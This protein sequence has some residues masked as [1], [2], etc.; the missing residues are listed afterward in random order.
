[1]A[2]TAEPY[3][4]QKTLDIVFAASCA[5]MML[6]TIWMF[7]ADYRRD[8]KNTQRTFRDVEATLAEREMLDKLPDPALVADLR[9][10]VKAAKK[11][12]AKAKESV[13]DTERKLTAKRESADEHYRGIKADLDAESSYYNIAADE[14][15]SFPRESARHKSLLDE[16]K[17]IREKKVLPL[18]KQLAAA[19]TTLNEIDAEIKE[20]VRSVTDEPEKE[21]AAAEDELKKQTSVFDR[22]AKLASQK[23]WGSGDT[24]R[25]LP[26][27][28]GFESSTKIR[29]MWL[30]DLTIDMGGF[31]DAAR[32]DRCTTCHLGIDRATFEPERLASIGDDD[33]NRRL[34]GKLVDAQKML[35]D[36]KNAGE[37]LGFDPADLPGE[38]NGSV[39]WLALIMFGCVLVGA[40]SL[41]ALTQSPRV[42]VLLLAGG[43]L[44][45]VVTS[46]LFAYFA[47]RKPA[48]KTI[49]L[50]KSQVMEYASHPRLDL[51]VGGNSPHNAEKFGC[52]IC[53]AGQG[54]ATEFNLATHTPDDSVQTHAWQK[55]YHYH[56]SHDWDFPMLPKR[57]IESSCLKCHHQVTDLIRNGAKEEAPKLLRGF[58]LVKD[59]GCFGCHE[60][61][62]NK[63]GR[64]IGPDLRLESSP[65]LDL[66]TA[67][68]QER[69]KASQPGTLRK[70]GPS[71]R[72]LAEKTGPEWTTNW[73]NAPRD[74]RPDTKMP[75]F[76]HLVTNSKGD[77]PG[78]LPKD[79]ENFPAAEVHAISHYLLAESKAT[80]N[81]SDFYREALLKGKQNLNALQATLIK[82][83]LSDR[84]MK[85]LLDMSRRFVD[86]AI[87]SV[88]LH[89]QTINAHATRQRLLQDRIAELQRVVARGG[90][91]PEV[92]TEIDAAGK[93]LLAATDSLVK[94]GT[95]VSLADGLIDGLGEKVALPAADGNA[96]S[97]QRLFAEK[98][99]LACHGHEGTAKAGT[100]PDGKP[101]PAVR[102]AANFGPELSRIADK[103]AP[104][105]DKVTARMW[106]V[107]WLLNPNVH[108]PRTKMPITHL[109]VA[110]ANDVATWL[111]SQKTGWKGAPTDPVA[112]SVKDYKDL[113]RVYLAKS[114]GM[115]RTDLDIFFP[116]DGD[117]LAGISPERLDAMPRDADERVLVQG[118][119]TVE[120]LK[121]YIGKKAIGRQ[122]CYGCHD[123]PGFETAKPIGTDLNDW[124][125]KD[126]ARLAFEDGA[127]FVK[128]YYNVVPT[129]RTR[130]EVTARI[131][132]LTKKGDAR[133][134]PEKKE[135]KKLEDQADNQ[136]K[137]IALE[138]KAAG[139]GLSDTEAKQYRELE[140]QKFFEGVKE[141]DGPTK[142]PYEQAF[143]HALEH[144]QREGFLGLKLTNPRSYDYN[145]LRP[146]DDRLRMPQFKFA[147]VRQT[148]GESD[149]AYQ[150]RAEKLEA[151]AREAVMT[152]ILGLVAEPIPAKYVA[153]PKAERLAE[154]VGRQVLDKYNC[155]G[156]HQIAPGVYDFKVAPEIT[157]SL[158]EIQKR[159]TEQ[160]GP[161]DH[162]FLNHNGWFGTNPT[163]DRLTAFGLLDKLAGDQLKDNGKNVDAI[164]LSE[165]LR[166]YG[167]DKVLRDL[168]AGNTIELPTDGYHGT[169][170][171]G[172]TFTDLMIP[173]LQKK[174]STDF[175]KDE[176]GL[177]P[178][179][180]AVL[181]PPLMR[182]GERVQPDWLY[183]FLLEPTV[184]RPEVTML[185]RMP[186]FNMSPEESKAIVNYFAAV[187]RSTNPGAGVTFPYLTIDQRE[188]N[189]WTRIAGRHDAEAKA[190]LTS[191]QAEV[192]RLAAGKDEATRKKWEDRVK[193]IQGQLDLKPKAGS[194]VADL[195]SRQAYQLLTDKN[196]CLQCHTV[197]TIAIDKPQAPNLALAAERIRPEWMEMWIA[198]PKR[199]FTYEPIMPVNFPNG[200]DPLQWKYQESFT[201]PPI[202]EV[203]AVR[204]LLLDGP[205]LID[206]IATYPPAAT[207]P[208]VPP[209]EKEKDKD[210]K[211]KK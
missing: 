175:P 193:L 46:G 128:D 103:L 94:A 17:H 95:P 169:A 14:A 52:T 142:P 67:A 158:Q 99:C 139:K 56:P 87:L 42:G 61:Y 123:I 21:L 172:G 211:D 13:A 90:A 159:S 127:S 89:N 98:G 66:L 25:S 173:Y 149:A 69:A 75:H 197:G 206:L 204:D 191:A 112:P 44:M 117:V 137:I 53:H 140:P 138:T 188:K 156:C 38:S 81:G 22:F 82:T 97:G 43:A 136:E 5:A 196:L 10:E 176:R 118:K 102:S 110:Q 205:R 182:E 116:A 74:F 60:I 1:M 144:H 84:E 131:D 73:V 199:M 100:G 130:A 34:M 186:K 119:T 48:I 209:K 151:E 55:E 39:G 122:G 28:D 70:V 36:R 183:K 23:A 58:N 29:Q 129:R 45:T 148:V 79:Q 207:P 101:T 190:E 113:A 160:E 115:T 86:L 114:P 47:P 181:P 16:S 195:Y 210:K 194:K 4:S 121:W 152:F 124:G 7:A 146:W 170:A 37:N 163:S 62:G 40:I 179:S 111:L 177:F 96:G 208:P 134:G 202:Q 35:E 31:K 27:L 141:G 26:I 200:H 164:R 2:A 178:K 154:V 165:A 166:F 49:K 68:E 71:L 41:T 64:S 180:R 184:I 107:Q 192:K 80:L 105:A 135:L 91:A 125:K 33:E 32:Y 65:A 30:P 147:R 171:Y 57:F 174:N 157:D 15:G 11:R 185:L 54:S 18:E 150:A 85:D 187:A 63:G 168:P 126:N 8:Y 9:R 6:S 3:R 93:E 145:R 59:M 88:P 167:K 109:S 189:Y 201:G 162:V 76:Y 83:G 92:K 77:L 106:L 143:Y 24:F 198:N 20:K 133:T 120:T 203:R 108:H 161:T 50:S 104:V 155:A 132:A 12:L 51:F 153:T 19:Q 72:R 78:N